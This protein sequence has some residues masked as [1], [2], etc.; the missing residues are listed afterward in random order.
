MEL[1]ENAVLYLVVDLAIGCASACICIP[2]LLGA[3]LYYFVKT[4]KKKRY[5]NY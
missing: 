3:G 2:F 5:G 1:L 4:F